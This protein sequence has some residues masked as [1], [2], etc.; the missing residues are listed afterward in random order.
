MTDRI[1]LLLKARNITASQFADEIGV[2]RS[3]ISHVLSGRNKPSLDFIQKIL[4][5]FPEINPDWLLFGK[6]PMNTEFNLFSETSEEL[7]LKQEA[8]SKAL[9]RQ[10]KGMRAI[11]ERDDEIIRT[12]EDNRN[13]ELQPE[14][15]P[16]QPSQP[17]V[18]QEIKKEELAK[19]IPQDFP[20]SRVEVRSFVQTKKEIEKI[21]VFYKDKS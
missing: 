5:R 2:Q 9:Q 3:S 11:P 1:S 16:V 4:K 15:P 14:I 8:I 10:D 7:P 21:V 12:I 13:R 19:G 6:G 18:K 20:H 17:T